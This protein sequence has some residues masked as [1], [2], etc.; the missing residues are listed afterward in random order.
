ML[1]E[2]FPGFL[3]VVNAQGEDRFLKQETSGDS[4]WLVEEALSL[5]TPLKPRCLTLPDEFDPT[6]D[7]IEELLSPA[8]KN[9]R[10]DFL[11]RREMEHD[12]EQRRMHSLTHSP[13]RSKVLEASDLPEFDERLE[14]PE[15][16]LAGRGGGVGPPPLDRRN[17]PPLS[18]EQKKRMN[19][20]LREWSESRRKAPRDELIVSVDG[21]ERGVLNLSAAPNLRLVLES[22]NRMIEFTG[23][24]EGGSVLLGTHLLQWDEDAGAGDSAAFRLALRDRHK[25]EVEFSYLRREDELTGAVAEIRYR[26]GLSPWV[27]PVAAGALLLTASTSFLIFRYGRRAGASE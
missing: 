17:I 26:K 25:V 1:A 2:R 4:L 8:S 12:V 20:T 11:A 19:L 5:F 27:L 21:T 9:P 15:F 6:A 13:C 3:Q 23:R 16:F 22:H 18:R 24:G 7:V 14:V 10:A